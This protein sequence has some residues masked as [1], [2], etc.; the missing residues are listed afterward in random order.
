LCHVFP[1]PARQVEAGGRGIVTHDYIFL[2]Q[3]VSG[4]V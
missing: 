2:I 1:Y 3:C 4:F